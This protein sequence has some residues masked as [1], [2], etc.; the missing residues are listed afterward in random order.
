MKVL[1]KMD[2]I[3]NKELK[4]V[5]VDVPEWGGSLWVQE[6]TGEQRDR[7]DRWVTEK[8]DGVGGFR[9][10]VLIATVVDEEGI[11]LFS[12]LDIPDLNK[13]SGKAVAKLSDKGMELSGMTEGAKEVEIKNSEA[14]LKEDSSSVSVEK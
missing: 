14:V 4:K 3:R 5:L 7:F 13:K 10:R 1:S 11:P 9:V 8:A 2:V 12:D 6:M